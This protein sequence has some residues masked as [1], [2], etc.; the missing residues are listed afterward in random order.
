[1]NKKYIKIVSVLL[2]GMIVTSCLANYSKKEDE[3][4]V[5]S[6]SEKAENNKKMI[7]EFYTA[8]KN[9]DSAK[10]ASLYHDEVEFEDP[11][12]GKLKG[13][14]AK[15]MWKMLVEKGGEGLKVNFSNIKAN[16]NFATA[17]W[18][19]DYMFSQTKNQVHNE[20]KAS[21]EFK[22]GKIYKHKDSFD[23]WKWASMAFGFLGSVI[24]GT[25]FF[26]SKLTEEAN[27]ELTKYM[28]SKK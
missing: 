15:S 6:N 17:E 16:D 1:M 28:S 10:M 8:F 20:I 19:A 27:K 26:K 9:H 24:G 2:L 3:K 12:F 5:E 14:R 4:F 23:S 18:V 7:S 13:E 22:D 25:P 11:A 21:F